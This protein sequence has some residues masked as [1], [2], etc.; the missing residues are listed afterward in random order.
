MNGAGRRSRDGHGLAIVTASTGARIRAGKACTAGAEKLRSPLESNPGR[1]S[2]SSRGGRMTRARM[3][4]VGVVAALL[5]ASASVVGAS[6][7]PGT[8][9]K[10]IVIGYINHIDS[11]PFVQ[12]VRKSIQSQG[13]KNGAK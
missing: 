5:V 1:V 6:A 4:V 7:A 10:Q 8:S 11:I 9:Q 2:P 3:A 13:Q 12:L